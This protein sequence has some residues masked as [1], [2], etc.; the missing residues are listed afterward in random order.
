MTK[1]LK[2]GIVGYGNLGMAVEQNLANNSE[3]ELIAIFSKRNVKSNLGNKVENANNIYKYE[4]EIDVLFLCGGSYDEVENTAL[5][6]CQKFDTIDCFDTHAKMQVYSQNLN[7]ITKENKRISLYAC[8]WD[9]GLFSVM[10]SL[11]ESICEKN[12][13]TFWGKGVSQGHTNALKQIDGIVDALQYTIPN[14]KV[15][16][17]CKNDCDYDVDNN[18]K[19]VRLCYVV[20][21][22]KANKK[23]IVKYIKSVPNYFQGQKVITKFVSQNKLNKLKH[24]K[25]HKGEVF[26]KL[27]L[28]NKTFSMNFDLKLESNPIFTA[29]VM[30]VCA[31]ALINL[32]YAHKYGAY[33]MLD[34]PIK[35]LQTDSKD[36]SNL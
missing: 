6:L 19:H 10:R 28:C 27:H 35:Y 17:K 15:L 7:K 26:G 22:K 33:S 8:G 30:L 12:V 9:P 1:K 32:K 13:Q 3:M 16:A 34:L 11:F 36:I 23:Q 21:D 5:A 29:R 18:Q 4:G 24:D 14:K 31:R 2:V 20:K 25:S